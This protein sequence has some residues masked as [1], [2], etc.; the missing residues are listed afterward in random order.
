MKIS[1]F[2]RVI[3]IMDTHY[4]FGDERDCKI[5][6][7]MASVLRVGITCSISIEESFF[8]FLQ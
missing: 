5:K 1:L 4:V 2:E 3:E 6:E 8:L 7:Y